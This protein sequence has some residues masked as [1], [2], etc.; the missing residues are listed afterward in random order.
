MYFLFKGNFM[1]EIKELNTLNNRFRGLYPVVVDVETAG[2]NA[3]TDALLEIAAITLKM[4][5]NGWLKKDHILHF[6]II[7]FLG[8][9]LKPEALAFNKINPHSPLR[10]AIHEIE[11]LKKLFS[12]V[13][14]GMKQQNCNRAIL[15]AHN[16]TFDLSFIQA[17]VQ[18]VEIKKNPFHSFV[19]FDTATLSGLLLGQTVLA[20]ACKTIG[21]NFDNQQ[22]HSALYDTMQTAKL[23]CE[24]VNYWKRIGGWKKFFSLKK[25]K[26]KNFLS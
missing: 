11:A 14:E 4:D 25:E 5:E 8:S 3:K 18:R 19:T 22:A 23:F 1:L 6:H 21:I 26:K 20:R 9:I 12:V 2:L 10:D 24:L 16:A 17:A 7:P 13:F 15:V